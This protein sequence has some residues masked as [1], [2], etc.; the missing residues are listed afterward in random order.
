[1]LT[2]G[3]VDHH[4][5]NWHADTFL[6][7]L[8]GPLADREIKIV[9][10]WE[11]DPTGDDWC[12]KTGVPRA[13]TPEEAATG[14]DAVMVLAPD[15][16]DAHLKLAARV[17]PFGK[18]TLVDKFLAPT[19]AE[20]KEIVALAKRHN[21]PLLSASGLR[22]A[23]ELDAVMPELAAGTVTEVLA[24]GM[25]HWNAYGIH[26]LALA[27]RITGPT[28][29]R[30]IDTGTPTART[31][32]LDFGEGRRAV[33][34]VR[35]AENEWDVLGWTFAARVGD[36]YVSGAVKDYEGFYAGLMKQ[37]AEFFRTGK[38]DMPVEEALTAVAVLEAANRS[39]QDG[40]AWITL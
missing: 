8:H 16:I 1:M 7:L 37:A 27:L 39:Q 30:V 33:V 12:V 6:R 35:Q 40:G 36:R 28:V 25:G 23:V 20:A 38:S 15:N 18:P 31:V 14:V 26:T 24:H 29:R 22:C 21:A 9:K 3:I 13:Q 34:D 32:T 4:L 5:N 17:L 19:L 2:V 10:A 11:S